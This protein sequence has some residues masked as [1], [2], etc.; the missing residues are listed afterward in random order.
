MQRQI[1]KVLIIANMSKVKAA[2]LVSEIQAY[3]KSLDIITEVFGFK[4]K[5]D[6]PNIGN[7]DLVISLGGDGTVLFCARTLQNRGVPI[8]AVNLGSFGFIT[9]VSI[10]EWKEAFENYRTGATDLSRRLMIRVVVNRNGERVYLGRGLNDMVIKGNGI[11][12][13][14]RI[15]LHLNESLLGSFRSDG[16]IVAS[17]TGSTAYSL[18]AGGPILDSEMDAMIVTPISPLTLS[19]RPL[20]V[21][22]EDIIR[23]E[24]L[25]HQRTEI[26]LS[27]DGQE[28]FP[29]KEGDS[30]TIEKSRSRALLVMS[31]KRNFYEVVRDKLHWSGGA[32]A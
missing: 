4:G 32:N 21:S 26:N 10:D 20:V 19:I 6:P 31:N 1:R 9:E 29:L 7:V 22:G 17:P 3:L 12:Q 28:L 23:V 25:E 27:I 14:I 8:L 18:A 24:I 2:D 16:I 30:I 11:S 5:S 15:Q 13:V